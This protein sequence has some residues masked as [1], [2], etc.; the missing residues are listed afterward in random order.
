M[1]SKKTLTLKWQ[2]LL[3]EGQTCRRC[4]VT[5]V[6]IEKA[7]V[8]LKKAFS[9]LGIDVILEKDELSIEEFK[10]DTLQSNMIWLNG[11]LLED[12][13]EGKPGKSQCDD[14]CGL[15]ECRTVGV[16]EE[17]YETIP[18]ELIVKAGLL[19]A[20]QLLDPPFSKRVPQKTGSDY[21]EQINNEL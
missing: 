2:R 18:A 9:P 11:R 21:G 3:S 14:V 8:A 16:E 6:E 1:D 13:I 15:H 19:A 4:G 17:V 7:M 20:S 10:K 12:W 5:E